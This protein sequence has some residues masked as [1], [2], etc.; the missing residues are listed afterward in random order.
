MK[1]KRKNYTPEEKV[2]I[3]LRHLLELVPISELCDKHG[4]QPTI[5]YRCQKKFFENG[6]A[7]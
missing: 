6:T 5:F 1:K 4:L 7:A 2:A 3:L